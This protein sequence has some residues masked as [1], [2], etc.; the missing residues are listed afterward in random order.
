M[1]DIDFIEQYFFIISL[2]HL[3]ANIV[4]PF[5]Q[6]VSHILLSKELI[7]VFWNFPGKSFF[8]LM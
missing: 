3:S 5:P 4:I 8:P 7:S 1:F 2:Y 6:N